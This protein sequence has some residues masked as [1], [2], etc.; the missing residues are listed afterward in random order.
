[1]RV[2]A[3]SEEGRPYPAKLDT[4]GRYEIRSLPLGSWLIKATLG[5][6]E[7]QVQADRDGVHA[8]ADGAEL[9]VKLLGLRLAIRRVKRGYNAL[10]R[11]LAFQI[12]RRDRLHSA[13]FVGVQLEIRS[14]LPDFHG[15]AD[16]GQRIAFKRNGSA[17]R[18]V[19]CPF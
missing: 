10:N 17:A 16:K 14:L 4:T 9:I 8:I 3:R 2:E 1:M 5:S 7:R 19:N 12:G 18:H 13:G 11:R 6:G 15:F